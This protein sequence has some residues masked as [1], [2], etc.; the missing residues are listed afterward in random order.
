MKGLLMNEDW[1]IIMEWHIIRQTEE[2]ETKNGGRRERQGEGS[3][4]SDDDQFSILLLHPSHHIMYSSYS[5]TTNMLA[6]YFILS[7]LRVFA[8]QPGYKNPVNLILIFLC[9]F[10]LLNLLAGTTSLSL[11]SPPCVSLFSISDFI[12]FCWSSA[13][14]LEK[15]AEHDK[16]V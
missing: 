7:I 3:Y 14:K 2:L 8:L 1:N 15:K 6:N 16:S 4:F 11:I 13:Q 12:S 10:S 9:L 5:H